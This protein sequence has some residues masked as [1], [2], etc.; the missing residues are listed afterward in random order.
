[1]AVHIKK[2]IVSAWRQFSRSKLGVTGLIIIL[3]FIFV[4]VAAPIISPYDPQVLFLAPR[5]SAPSFKYLLG[6]DDVGR[7]VFSQIIYGSR[8]SLTVGLLAAVVGT[9]L[10]TTIGLVSGYYG[11]I[12]D[13]IFMRITDIFL[14]IPF[15]PLAI[16]LALCVGPNIWNVILLLGFFGWPPAARQVRSLALSLKELPF[17]EAARAI[18]AGDRRIIFRHILPNVTGIIIAN[19]VSRTV[20]AILMEAGLAFLGASDPRNIS[21]GMMIFHAMRSGAVFYGAWWTYIPAGLCIAIL[22][23][24]FAFLGHGITLI[25]NPRLRGRAGL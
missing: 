24:G 22:A 18:G 15:I 25:L 11:G 7:D 5:F 19:V 20:F 16:L 23:C 3:I 21:W 12:L 4:A 2:D 1:M 10:G 14:V 6:T 9:S 13:D 17:I 8:I